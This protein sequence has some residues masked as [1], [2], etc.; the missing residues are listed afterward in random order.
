MPIKMQCARVREATR[1]RRDNEGGW[2]LDR[3]DCVEDDMTPGRITDVCGGGE[4]G[5]DARQL[6]RGAGAAFLMSPGDGSTGPTHLRRCGFWQLFFE[7]GCLFLGR[8]VC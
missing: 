4:R 5:G 1:D 6:G 7:S 8:R 3:I 2:Q